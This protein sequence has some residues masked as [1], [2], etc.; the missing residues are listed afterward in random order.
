M[1]QRVGHSI[2]M[3]PESIDPQRLMPWLSPEQ[4]QADLHAFS[5][6]LLDTPERWPQWWAVRSVEQAADF[7]SGLALDAEHKHRLMTQVQITLGLQALGQE[8]SDLK[9]PS[10]A[11]DYGRQLAPTPFQ[12]VWQDERAQL[13]VYP[14]EGIPVVW[15]PAVINKHYILDLSPQ[16][17]VI[18]RMQASGCQVFSVIWRN[19]TGNPGPEEYLDSVQNALQA[20]GHPVHLAGYCLGGVLAAAAVS[21][22]AQVQSLSLIAAPL[23]GQMG[24]SSAWFTPLQRAHTERCA[25]TR[26]RVPAGV[27]SAGFLALKPASWGGLFHEGR[28]PELAAW[29]MDG[30]DVSPAMWSWICN[31]VYGPGGAIQVYGLDALEVPVWNQA[32][33]GDH[34]VKPQTFETR[35]GVIQTRAPGG[36]NGGLLRENWLKPWINWLPGGGQTL[37]PPR[38]AEPRDYL[39]E[40][41]AAL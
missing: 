15:V 41:G 14:G 3:N 38:V 19:P 7:L 21:K 25:Q 24:E 8:F 37:T 34:L 23:D 32:F 20:L 4:T 31:R 28:Y 39:T 30:L 33:D 13:V 27:L 29:L 18:R 17:S 1:Q 35:G 12:V 26:G 10:G 16:R 2:K 40:S 6:V 9:L 5:Q 11:P 22:G 36:H